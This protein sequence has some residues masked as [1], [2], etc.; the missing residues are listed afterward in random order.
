VGPD[1]ISPDGRID[2]GKPTRAHVRRAPVPN[3]LGSGQLSSRPG[4][5]T[6]PG[7]CSDI[8]Y[9]QRMVGNSTVSG[10]V[11]SARAPDSAKRPR[12]RVRDGFVQRSLEYP[13]PPG[14]NPQAVKD[15]LLGYIRTV[16]EALG[17]QAD[18]KI[19]FNLEPW[20]GR[21]RVEVDYSAQE[22]LDQY[23]K[24]LDFL[25]K[26]GDVVDKAD[27]F[28]VAGHKTGVPRALTE[29]YGDFLDKR[30]STQNEKGHKEL[31]T[32]AIRTA[33]HFDYSEVD[34]GLRYRAWEH[35]YEEIKDSPN[36]TKGVLKL[37]ETEE[38]VIIGEDH[39]DDQNRALLIDLLP[40]LSESNVTTIYLEAIR[41]DYQPLVDSYLKSPV[42]ANMSPELHR[43]LQGKGTEGVSY[44]QVLQAVKAQGGLLVKSIDSLAATSRPYGGN[45]EN[46]DVARELAMNEYAFT[47]IRHDKERTKK[48]K[49]VILAGRAHS[50]TQPHRANEL[51]A[52]AA[53]PGLSQLLNIPAVHMPKDGDRPLL[54]PEERKNR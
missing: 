21:P 29:T 36:S 46:R 11:S 48:S 28:E 16:N 1:R 40:H 47:T 26:A 39:S 19:K 23:P 32:Q 41:A 33:Q 44:F 51:G 6:V 18:P 7:T 37:L 9:L 25:N 35:Q 30:A 14:V 4:D 2:V 20:L 38:G 5:V 27:L 54:D 3:A 34:S 10:L 15:D 42:N 52:T 49:Y 17:L 43:F 50:N 12:A 13:I 22:L 31:L 8:L 24:F 53:V 45:Q